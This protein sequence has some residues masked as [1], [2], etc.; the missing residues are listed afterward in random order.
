MRLLAYH[1]VYL[2]WFLTRDVRLDNGRHLSAV[3]PEFRRLTPAEI[4]GNRCASYVLCRLCYLYY[5]TSA[6]CIVSPVLPVLCRLCYV[7]AR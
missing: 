5:V 1:I 4:S 7:H 2:L 3:W 6:T